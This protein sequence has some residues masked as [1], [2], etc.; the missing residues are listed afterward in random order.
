MEDAFFTNIH[1]VSTKDVSCVHV[2][3]KPVRYTAEAHGKHV[4]RVCVCSVCLLCVCAV[5]VCCVCVLLVVKGECKLKCCW[6]NFKE[7]LI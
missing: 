5:C 6:L 4:L 2:G 3:S 7:R 1:D